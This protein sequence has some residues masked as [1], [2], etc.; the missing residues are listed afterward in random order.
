[1]KRTFII[2]LGV[3]VVA[4]ALFMNAAR[5]SVMGY[6]VGDYARDFSLPDV[7][8]K[9]VSL[10][11]FSSAKGFIVVFTCNTC[12]YAVSYEDRIAKLDKNYRDKGFPVI[13]INPNDINQ[14][15]KESVKDMKARS[16]E[17]GFTFP[18]LRDDTQEIARAYGASK[19]PH[20]YLL[21]NGGGDKFR[22]EFIGAIDDSPRDEAGVTVRYVE[23][24][25]NALIAGKKPTVTEARAIGCTIKWKA[26]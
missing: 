13:A 8:G 25:I 21:S 5:S 9:M 19:T 14:E 7:D 22:V 15:P 4:A 2:L 17:K 3:L 26:S 1:M 10:K 16:L 11:D 12:P 18:Y 6:A 23:D 24:A 20:V